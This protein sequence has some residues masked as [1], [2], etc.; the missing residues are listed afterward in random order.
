MPSIAKEQIN[1]DDASQALLLHALMPSHTV[2][3]K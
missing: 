1:H 3:C 2:F